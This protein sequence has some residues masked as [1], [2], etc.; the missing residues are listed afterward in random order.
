MVLSDNELIIN[1]NK[2]DILALEELI[3]RYD[4]M[5]LRLAMKY[6]GD[7][8]DAKDIYQEVFIRVYKSL[9]S[10]QFKSEFSTW[11]FRITSNVCIS[12]KRKYKKQNHLS[13]NDEENSGYISTIIED[14]VLSPD[15]VFVNSEH[16][17]KINHALNTLSPNQKMSFLLKHYEGFKIRE[18]AEMMNCKEGTIKKYLFEA[19]RKLKTQLENSY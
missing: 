7:S 12:F 16:G 13:L 14:E 4:K 3:Y 11:L 19:V 10:F 1:A 9:S 5:V 15:N 17:E 8:D 6:T 18:I 2:G